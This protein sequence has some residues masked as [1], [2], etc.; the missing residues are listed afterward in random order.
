MSNVSTGLTGNQNFIRDYV[1][2]DNVVKITLAACFSDQ[3]LDAIIEVGR[4]GRG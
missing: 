2:I 4:G 1:Y 3:L